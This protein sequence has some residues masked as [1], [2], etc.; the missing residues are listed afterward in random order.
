M[1]NSES[2]SKSRISRKR[3]KSRQVNI[4]ENIELTGVLVW[5]ITITKI[6]AIGLRGT[7]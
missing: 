7:Q 1:W 6:V 4:V 2:D 3:L 5:L